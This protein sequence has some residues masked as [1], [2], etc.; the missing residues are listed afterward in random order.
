VSGRVHAGFACE[1][2]AGP[3]RLCDDLF[4][5]RL[6]ALTEARRHGENFIDWN[7][8][9]ALRLDCPRRS[10]RPEN[11]HWTFVSS[12]RTETTSVALT[13]A[14][15]SVPLCLREIISLRANDHVHAAGR[16]GFDWTRPLLPCSGVDDLF[17][18]GS[19]LSRRHGDT[20]RTSS[21]E[22]AKSH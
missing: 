9:I 15:L 5:A 21:I 7:S 2:A 11:L 19:W 3:A 4:A 10:K 20:E 12:H 16:L 14:F 17:A 6:L 22:T 1:P 8:Q 18:L 13:V